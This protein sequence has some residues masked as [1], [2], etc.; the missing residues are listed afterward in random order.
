MA[1]MAKPF[2]DRAIQLRMADVIIR[3][4]RAVISETVGNTPFQKAGFK[5][6]RRL[7]D[8]ELD[9]NFR[10]TVPRQGCQWDKNNQCCMGY[11]AERPCR[12]AAVFNCSIVKPKG[13]KDDEALEGLG[14]LFG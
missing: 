6:E 7:K 14:A 3:G 10:P 8:E 11:S 13:D 5:I 1:G 4:D 12:N 2:G 9:E